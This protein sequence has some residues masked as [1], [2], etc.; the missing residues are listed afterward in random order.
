MV[1][2]VERFFAKNGKVLTISADASVAAAARG[3]SR[4]GIGC[5]V[6]MDKKLRVAGILT[7]R[8]IMSKVVA[9][10]ADPTRTPVADVMTTTVI[11]CSLDTEV[12]EAMEIMGQHGIRHLP[13]IEGEKV[14]GMISSRDILAHRLTT[15][16]ALVRQQTN[17]LAELERQ[18][19]GI[20]R[21]DVDPGGRLVL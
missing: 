9:A 16:D 17:V 3:M 10:A 12:E 13:I 19:P 18:H 1:S 4:H 5:L 15:V 21:V 8:D 20:T 7:E 14:R 2:Q 11:S 6:V